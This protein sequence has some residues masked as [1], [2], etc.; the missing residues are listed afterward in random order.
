LFNLDEN[1]SVGSGRIG[2]I[3]K[4]RKRKDEKEKDEEMNNEQQ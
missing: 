4:K 1:A 2:F 3:Y